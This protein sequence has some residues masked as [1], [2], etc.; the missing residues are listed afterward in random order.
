MRPIARIIALSAIVAVWVYA[1]W[2]LATLVMFGYSAAFYLGGMSYRG[3]M[4]SK[5]ED[6]RK[7]AHLEK[8]R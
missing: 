6:L 7:A 1:S 3:F 8:F 2:W 5:V 4:K